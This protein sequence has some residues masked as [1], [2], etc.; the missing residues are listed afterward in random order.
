M[1]F[2]IYLLTSTASMYAHK[3]AS[4]HKRNIAIVSLLIGFAAGMLSG[5]FF[6][7]QWWIIS[8]I[9]FV[10]IFLNEN[11]RKPILTGF[12]ADHVETKILTSVISAES[13]LKTI[14]TAGLALLFGFVADG[15]GIGW[16]LVVVSG[17]LIVVSVVLQNIR[18]KS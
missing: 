12:V 13:L 3:I 2:G 4:R 15:Y 1:Y 8:L 14:I 16:S 5:I 17:L 7:N 6:N 18:I 11:I 9:A 10:I